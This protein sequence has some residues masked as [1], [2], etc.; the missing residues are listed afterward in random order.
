[1]QAGWRLV[2]GK[3]EVV[4]QVV[5]A[6]ARAVFAVVMA[7]TEVC[8]AGAG[9]EKSVAPAHWFLGVGSAP[10]WRAAPVRVIVL[11][12]AVPRV[13]AVARL[14]LA[15]FAVVRAAELPVYWPWLMAQHCP[16]RLC[17]AVQPRREPCALP[18]LPS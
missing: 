6:V 7:A 2:V 10:V 14:A 1:M 11:K 12:A 9:F 17:L 5:V 15:V 8:F 18:E 3:P 4:V 16:N 13:V